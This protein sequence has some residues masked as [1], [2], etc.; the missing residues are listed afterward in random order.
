M[1]IVENF[2][3]QR[4]CVDM[5]VCMRLLRII[6]YLSPIYY[7]QECPKIGDKIFDFLEQ[8]NQ[9]NFLF[10]FKVDTMLRKKIVKFFENQCSL[11][12]YGNKFIKNKSAREKLVENFKDLIS[13][14]NS[15][16]PKTPTLWSGL[17]TVPII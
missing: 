15:T 5:F 16:P 3:F 14:L 11:L 12:N 9:Y 6:K 1:R 17:E 2:W 4:K 7:V 13:P 10:K 8:F